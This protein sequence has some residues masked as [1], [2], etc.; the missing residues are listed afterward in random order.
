[1]PTRQQYVWQVTSE[2]AG[3]AQRF[4]DAFNLLFGQ[5]LPPPTGKYAGIFWGAFQE[6]HVLGRCVR[7]GQTD[8]PPIRHYHWA[9]CQDSENRLAVQEFWHDEIWTTAAYQSVLATEGRC[10]KLP[11][12]AIRPDP[13]TFGEITL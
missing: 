2:L 3:P 11:L 6:A 4:V 13:G 9:V 8:D 12:P 1:M 7:L 5:E 10:P